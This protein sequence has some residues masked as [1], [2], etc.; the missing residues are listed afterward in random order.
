[1]FPTFLFPNL[2]GHGPSTRLTYLFSFSWRGVEY[3][4]EAGLSWL[5]GLSMDRHRGIAWQDE[6]FVAKLDGASYKGMTEW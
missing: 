3:V 5:G 2:L 6:A 4:F 1:M